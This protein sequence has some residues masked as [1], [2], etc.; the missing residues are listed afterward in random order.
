MRFEL[1]RGAQADL[2]FEDE[3]AAERVIKAT[4]TS[5][6]QRTLTFELRETL[7][8]FVRGLLL[9]M[10]LI[11][12]VSAL[13][14]W[15]IG[16]VTSAA[17]G[18]GVGAVLVGPLAT[19]ALA[20]WLTRAAAARVTIGQ[21][22]IVL[23]RW[24]TTRFVPHASIGGF[25]ARSSG[26]DVDLGK[27]Q[28][29]LSTIGWSDVDVERAMERLR[30]ARAAFDV[31]REAGPIADTTF[32]R[33]G[34][35]VGEWRKRMLDADFRRRSV[36]AADAEAVLGDPTQPLEHRAGAAIAL[37]A[38]EPGQGTARVRVAAEVAAEPEAR[39]LLLATLE[40]DPE[41]DAALDELDRRT[42]NDG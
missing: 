15:L 34:Q 7:G 1:A 19:L 31:A 33:R 6:E 39:Q 8:P 20:W 32:V 41:V 2:D 42:E 36:T 37:R 10:L 30:S 23:R 21:D 11:W 13:A 24:W 17:I 38:L 26:I 16:A 18:L 9:Y 35:S 25:S 14:S 3:S 5:V 27:E 22:G 4:G 29:H 28:L 40:D 12:P